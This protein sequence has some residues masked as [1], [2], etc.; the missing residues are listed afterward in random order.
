MVSL[1]VFQNS[2]NF[3]TTLA[4]QLSFPR[5]LTVRTWAPPPPPPPHCLSRGNC[6]TAASS[7]PPKIVLDSLRVLEWDK[8]CD[9]VASFAATSLGKKAIKEQLWSLNKTYDHS[10][11]LLQETNAIVE[12]YN[13]G[14]MVDFVPFHSSLVSLHLPSIPVQ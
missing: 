12:M 3:V 8:L 14:A 5:I 4:S 9:S 7:P 1:A 11:S 6:R 13:Y 10:L 2:F